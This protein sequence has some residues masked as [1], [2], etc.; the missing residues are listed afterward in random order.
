MV[1]EDEGLC[2]NRLMLMRTPLELAV[3]RLG[4]SSWYG[5]SLSVKT[6]VRTYV[7]ACISEGYTPSSAFPETTPPWPLGKALRALGKKL[8]TTWKTKEEQAPELVVVA[9]YPI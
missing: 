6:P 9:P 1:A 2:L 5:T 3:L 8:R 7:P 4:S